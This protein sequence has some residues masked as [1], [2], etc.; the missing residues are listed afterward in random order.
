VTSLCWW[1][2]K[3]EQFAV[4]Y[5]CYCQIWWRTLREYKKGFLEAVKI[6]FQRRFKNRYNATDCKNK[7]FSKLIFKGSWLKTIVLKNWFLETVPNH[8]FQKNL[9]NI[10]SLIKIKKYFK[11]SPKVWGPATAHKIYFSLVSNEDRPQLIRS[12]FH[13]FWISVDTKIQTHN[14]FLT[15]SIAYFHIVAF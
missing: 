11:C 3:I 12:T 5:F 15:C 10:W 2:Q 13:L 9:N 4:G 8:N 7:W 6:S 1:T 14:L